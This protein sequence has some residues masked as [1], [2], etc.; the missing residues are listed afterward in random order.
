MYLFFREEFW[1]GVSFSLVSGL[2]FNGASPGCSS[3]LGS[4][5][6]SPGPVIGVF[7]WV[8][9]S[10]GDSGIVIVGSVRKGGR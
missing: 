3:G 8:G 2:A 6:K 1:V 10:S 5:G 9:R 7:V 4:R